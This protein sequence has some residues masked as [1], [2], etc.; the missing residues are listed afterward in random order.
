M[1]LAKYGYIV[2]VPYTSTGF[3]SNTEAA[4]GWCFSVSPRHHCRAARLLL[5]SIESQNAITLQLK[6]STVTTDLYAFFQRPASLCRSAA[7]LTEPRVLSGQPNTNRTL[8]AL[9]VNTAFGM[10]LP[11]TSR[12]QNSSQKVNKS[13]ECGFEKVHLRTHLPRH[14]VNNVRVFAGCQQLADTIG[15]HSRRVK[16]SLHSGLGRPLKKHF[17]Y[18]GESRRAC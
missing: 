13:P 6:T 4:E 9:N 12:R 10:S 14:N 18:R 3:M 8:R 5:M 1:N 2:I 11:A 16:A 15:A 7:A 17:H